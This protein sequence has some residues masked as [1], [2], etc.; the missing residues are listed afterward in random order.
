MSK[1]YIDIR[2]VVVVD[3]AA[4]VAEVVIAV[5]GD[6]ALPEAELALAALSSSRARG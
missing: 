1:A 5:D 2:A 4:D 3:A 6:E